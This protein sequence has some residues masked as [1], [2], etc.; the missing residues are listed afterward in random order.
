MFS[1]ECVGERVAK[2]GQYLQNVM[3]KKT[4]KPEG[5]LLGPNCIWNVH[6]N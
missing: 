4:S 5:L 2:I 1:A 3:T 6:D